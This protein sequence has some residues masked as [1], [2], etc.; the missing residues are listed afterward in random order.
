MGASATNRHCSSAAFEL[1]AMY[2][3]TPPTGNHRQ[4]SV[5]VGSYRHPTT[6]AWGSKWAGAAYNHH[7]TDSG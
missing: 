1:R 6:A 7:G 3:F 4:L 5:I 2:L